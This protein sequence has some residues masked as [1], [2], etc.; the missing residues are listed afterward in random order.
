MQPQNPLESGIYHWKQEKTMTDDERKCRIL[1]VDDMPINLQVLAG[2]LKSDY[3]VKIATDG[4]KAIEIAS[5]E[6][7]PDLILLDVM[8]PEM[9]GIEV[10][11]RL[12]ND[13]K[14]R[15]IP[16]IFITVKDKAEDEALGLD[17]GAADYI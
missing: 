11:R 6:N 1:I 16:V 2:F 10:C 9:D 14:T 15:T 5:S 13:D 7:P 3:H 12:K 4:K 8:M 17:A